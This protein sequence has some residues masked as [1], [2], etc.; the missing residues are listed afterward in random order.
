MVEY[1]PWVW[2]GNQPSQPYKGQSASR[3]GPFFQPSQPSEAWSLPNLAA[4]AAG[5]AL[6]I[7]GPDKVLG[8][9]AY[10]SFT[11]AMISSIDAMFPLGTA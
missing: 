4:V 8:V 11:A 7:G 1:Q 10:H 6:R 5:L 3:A 9:L 2:A